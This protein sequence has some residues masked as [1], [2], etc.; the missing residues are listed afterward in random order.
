MAPLLPHVREFV[1]RAD[2]GRFAVETPIVIDVEPTDADD[3]YLLIGQ[4]N[5]V[6]FSER[7]AKRAGAGEPDEPHPRVK[8]LNV[9]SNSRLL[10]EDDPEEFVQERERDHSR[11]TRA[12]D[13]LHRPRRR[14]D[15][16]K[17]GDASIGPG[18]S[19]GKAMLAHTTRDVYLVPGAWSATGFCANA[20]GELGWNAEPRAEPW[21]GGSLLLER[22]LDRLDRTL[23]ETNGVLRGILWHQGRADA[24]NRRCAETYA[25]NLVKMLER[26]RGEARVDRRGPAARGPR[27]QIPFVVATMSKGYD[28]RGDYRRTT[29]LGRH[30]DDTHRNIAALVPYADFVNT[31]DLVPPAHPCGRSSCVHF[32]ATAMREQGERFAEAIRRIVTR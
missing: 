21:L 2:D 5:M 16:P 13:P 28:E 7:G 18:L 26:L 24:N 30:V 27:A 15:E 17:G 14:E 22:A 3:V 32:G 4:S 19:F 8:Q 12:E 10:A 6:G 31:D 29:E 1:L 20:L 11:F 25:E 23:R 9:R